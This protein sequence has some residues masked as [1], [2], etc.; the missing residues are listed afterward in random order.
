M[1]GTVR[2]AMKGKARS[3]LYLKLY[4]KVMA[5]TT[6]VYKSKNCFS[7]SE[8]RLEKRVQTIEMKSVCGIAVT[9]ENHHL[10]SKINIL[11]AQVHKY[12]IAG[13]TGYI[14]YKE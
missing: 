2:K 10:N 11:L 9:R 6:L 7:S 5:R 14:I 13:M 3:D 4:I 8:K 12:E 1:H